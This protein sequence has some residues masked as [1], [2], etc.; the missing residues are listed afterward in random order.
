MYK[1]YWMNS[2]KIS[3]QCP[4]ILYSFIISITYEVDTEKM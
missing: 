3:V 4:I 2:R 1:S